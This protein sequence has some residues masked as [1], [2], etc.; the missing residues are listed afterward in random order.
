MKRFVFL[1]L[2]S[3]VVASMAITLM[4]KKASAQT[5]ITGTLAAPVKI[6]AITNN[7][8]TLNSDTDCTASSAANPFAW[9]VCPVVSILGSVLDTTYNELI[10]P[11]LVVPPIP[12]P[13]QGGNNDKN[14]YKET[15]Q[16]WSNFRLIGNVLLIIVLLVVVFGESIGGGLIDAYTVKKIL[17]RL[18]IGAIL[19]NLSIYIVAFGIDVTNVVGAGLGNLLQAPFPDSAKQLNFNNNSVLSGGTAGNAAKGTLAIVGTFAALGAAVLAFEWVLLAVILVPTLLVFFITVVV[20]MIRSGLIMLLV[21]TA[22]V[23]FALWCLPNTEQYFKKWWSLLFRT[24][25]IFPII[26]LLF[27]LGNI[28]SYTVGRAIPDQTLG[29]FLKVIGIFAPFYLIPFSFQFAGGVIAGAAGLL[30]KRVAK[31]LTGMATG[32]AGKRGRM[33]MG[34]L[35]SGSHPWVPASVNRRAAGLA[36]GRKGRFGF[37]SRG[38]RAIEAKQE[39]A[40]RKRAQ[41]D[42]F[43]DLS[44][45]PEAAAIQALAGGSRDGARRARATLQQ[46][47]IDKHV[48]ANGGVADVDT[49]RNIQEQ[50]QSAEDEAANLG[51]NDENTRAAM[52]LGAAAQGASDSGVS[53]TSL[54]G[55]LSTSADAVSTNPDKLKGGFKYNA[56]QNGD[57]Y[58]GHGGNVGNIFQDHDAQA[59]LGSRPASIKAIIGD[60]H[61]TASDTT[62]PL[63]ERQ[64]AVDR[65][66]ALRDSSR[67]ASTKATDLSKQNLQGALDSLQQG[68]AGAGWRPS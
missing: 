31:P 18:L 16:I 2:T 15:Y 52:Q 4:P 17:P 24:L 8:G 34:K 43:K 7:D 59:I 27:A 38:A 39:A 62:R 19:I 48:Q 57:L 1:L 9:I 67:E 64:A 37:G 30:N 65:L 29:Q 33:N 22:P 45:N 58:L 23:A 35:A 55:L 63:P 5:N 68:G 54:D 42:D 14:A 41:E 25:L 40:A 44:M 13:G 51:F 32:A 20:L 47:A 66:A 21:Y 10:Y 53:A 60:L 3:V 49:V 12:L 26:A 56:K 50:W 6:V 46:A 36:S 28:V 11:L 61:Q